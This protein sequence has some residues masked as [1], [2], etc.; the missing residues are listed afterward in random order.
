MGVLDLEQRE[1]LKAQRVLEKA[2]QIEPTNARALSALGMALGNQKKY[3]EAIVPLER[4][5]ELDPACGWETHWSLAQSL[6]AVGRYEESAQ[7]LREVLKKHTD[8]PEAATARRFLA[9]LAADGKI[10]GQ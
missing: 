8:G 6:V 3:A 10:K 5:V 4:S 9:K 1:W 7:V 2:T